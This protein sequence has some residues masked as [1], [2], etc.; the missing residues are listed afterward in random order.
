MLSILAWVIGLTSQL[1]SLFDHTVLIRDAI[2]I[3]DGLFLLTKATCEIHEGIEGMGKAG[4]KIGKHDALGSVIVQIAMLDIVSSIDSVT[5]AIGMV[6]ELLIMSSA[7]ILAVI[8]L[9]IASGLF[10][11]FVA[12][13]PTVK[14]LAFS[15]FAF[16]RN[17][18]GG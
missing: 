17:D 5:T 12:Q 7:E 6:D 14:M 8:V 15:F 13:H 1:F 10:P 3:G 9:L 18:I 11:R 16:D 4:P 2:L